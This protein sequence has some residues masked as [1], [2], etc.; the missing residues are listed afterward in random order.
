MS[1]TAAQMPLFASATEPASRARRVVREQTRSSP[2]GGDVYQLKVTLKGIPPPIWRR[3]QVPAQ[4]SLRELH[5]VL[6]VVMGWENSHMHQFRVGK[7]YFE[8]PAP[9]SWM[10]DF[11]GAKSEDDAKT[12]LAEIA[13]R[14]A[15]KFVY[16]YDMGDS[17]EHQVVVE[18]ILPVQPAV[19]YPLCLDGGRAC[20]PEDCGGIWGYADL[21]AALE[22]PTQEG[23][24]EL[25]EWLG[26]GFD[27][28]HWDLDAV[29][30]QL[31]A[32]RVV[33][34]NPARRPP[35]KRR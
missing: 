14:V 3:V 20:P 35:A 19:H 6:Q 29:N 32:M 30:Q 34:K 5:Y 27:P 31:A 21:L 17:W 24:G 4:I 25:L 16:T 12:R 22:D 2:Q 9:K 28:E 15:A 1:K 10:L 33:G 18:K 8:A 26:D 11:F 7:R 13:P 23:A